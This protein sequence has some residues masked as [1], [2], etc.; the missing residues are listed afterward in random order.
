MI[1]V[2]VA[3]ID[4]QS[5]VSC[6]LAAHG[7]GIGLGERKPFRQTRQPAWVRE[8]WAVGR[9]YDGVKPR[10]LPPPEKLE[11]KFYY[12]ADCQKPEWAGVT[13][14]NIFMPRRA[15]RL[16]LELTEVRVQ[17]LQD[18]SDEDA[19][20]EGVNTDNP[21]SRPCLSWSPYQVTD[22]RWRYLLLWEHINGKGTARENPWVWTLSFTVH[23]QNIDAFLKA[24]EAAT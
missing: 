20:A 5:R 19:L 7:E 16:T 1:L 21:L 12:M 6:A 17:R 9:G 24:R 4:R 11:I 10:Q 8:N 14:P 18:I 15:S 23:Q 13:R 3:A 2:G 22:L